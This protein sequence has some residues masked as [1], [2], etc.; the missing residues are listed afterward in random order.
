MFRQQ[1]WKR[2]NAF[3]I[4]GLGS[5]RGRP[6]K[7]DAVFFHKL[8]IAGDVPAETVWHGLF[9][10]PC[11]PQIKIPAGLSFAGDYLKHHC[12]KSCPRLGRT[13]AVGAQGRNL[14]L[15]STWSGAGTARE[16]RVV[17]CFAH[18]S[19]Y[20]SYIYFFCNFT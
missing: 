10:Q 4:K 2:V 8:C 15:R 19:T 3:A 20:L 14:C 6:G 18:W 7:L 17:Y 5:P 16:Q 1:T 12:C 9:L 13:F 11:P